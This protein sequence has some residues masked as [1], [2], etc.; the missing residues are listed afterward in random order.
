MLVKVK[1]GTVSSK[2]WNPGSQ[3]RRILKRIAKRLT[4]RDGKRMCKKF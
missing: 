4:R 1:H 3:E 2:D